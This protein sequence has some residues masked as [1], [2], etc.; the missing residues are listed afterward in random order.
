[1]AATAEVLTPRP[2]VS[3]EERRPRRRWY[4]WIIVLLSVCIGIGIG[5]GLTIVSVIIPRSRELKRQVEGSVFL[6]N[7]EPAKFL[8][9]ATPNITWSSSS[10]DLKSWSASRV[11]GRVV[12][13]RAQ[14][15]PERQQMILQNVHSWLWTE[16]N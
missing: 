4:A 6:R 3:A 13:A 5:V 15:K 16:I 14:V 2:G 9:K 11:P 7:F 10:Q 12:E 8:S 1:M